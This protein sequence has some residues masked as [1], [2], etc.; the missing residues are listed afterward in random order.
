MIDVLI[1][2]NCASWRALS[3]AI[4]QGDPLLRIVGMAGDG[5]EAVKLTAKLKPD[6]IVMGSQLPGMGCFEATRKIMTES[7]TPI[8]M[9]ISGEKAT[10]DEEV[11]WVQALSAGALK[12]VHNPGSC[13]GA[14]FE[15]VSREFA[16]TLKALS[17]VK[18]VH[19]RTLV[20]ASPD[21]DRI[22]RCPSV[23]R[24]RA[25]VITIAC[26]TG[27]PPALANIFSRLPAD[28]PVPV[29]VVQHI[30][31]GFLPVL[32]DQL[33][34]SG[35]LKVK[36]AQAGEPALPGT[37]YLGP[38]EAH[39]GISRGRTII[40]SNTAPINNFRPSANYL[41]NSAAESYGSAAAAVVLTG[42][43]SDGVDG[44]KSIRGRGGRIIVQDQESSIVFGMP[45]SAIA[46][47][48]ADLV[49]PLDLIARHLLEIVDY[50]I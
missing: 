25:R 15:A 27:G 10:A 13:T 4:L 39:M 28:L 8:V 43:G 37:I 26:S 34:A 30:T 6:I 17:S 35:A 49:L 7:P 19:C 48:L 14:D 38:D 50:G 24:A 3:V 44:L 22:S 21:S 12:I 42:M 11:V 45:G 5:A 36:V 9:V 47:G 16:R 31:R 29:L 41:F 33:K 23:S 2:E 1:A 40:L 32:A 46:S 18:V 20:P